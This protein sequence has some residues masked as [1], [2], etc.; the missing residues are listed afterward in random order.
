MPVGDA[1]FIDGEERI[2]SHWQW[3]GII[4]SAIEGEVNYEAYVRW[5][6]TVKRW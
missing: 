4:R 1:I 3:K 5:Q 6:K 2:K